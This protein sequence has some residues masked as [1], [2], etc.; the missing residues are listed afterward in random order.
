MKLRDRTLL[1]GA[2][3]LSAVLIGAALLWNLD[4]RRAAEPEPAETPEQAAAPETPALSRAAAETPEGN[5][6][7]VTLFFQAPAGVISRGRS[8][9]SS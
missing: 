5:Q 2:I 6:R 7:E 9:R 8:A 1:F 3:G 4:S